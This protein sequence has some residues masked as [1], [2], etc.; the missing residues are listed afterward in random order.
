MAGDVYVLDSFSV[1]LLKKAVNIVDRNT[2]R[3]EKLQGGKVDDQKTIIQL[4]EEV[5]KKRSG[6][7][8]E[9]NQQFKL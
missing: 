2:E 1:P 8:S 9:V 4:Q 5:M 7:L 3:I 6:D